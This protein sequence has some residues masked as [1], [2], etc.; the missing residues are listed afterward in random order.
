LPEGVYTFVAWTHCSDD[1]DYKSNLD[2]LIAADQPQEPEDPEESETRAPGDGFKLEQL[3]MHMQVPEN[4]DAIE[5][6]FG[7]RHYGIL[8]RAYVS[9]NSILDPL[10]ATIEVSPSIH[11]VNFTITGIGY[12]TIDDEHTLTV[13]DNNSIHNFRNQYIPGLE[14]YHHRRILEKIEAPEQPETRAVEYPILHTSMHLMQLDD[15]TKTIVQIHNAENAAQP[16]KLH[17]YDINLVEMIERA[18]TGNN[19][20]VNFDEILEFDIVID[21]TARAQIT[22]HINGWSY[23]W[24]PADLDWH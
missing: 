12:N 19:Q 23:L 17:K 18:Y 5:Q 7:H 10:P 6:N 2:E 13:I 9:N 11:K 24:V 4:G 14:P 1:G 21:L 20:P 3:L 22:F 8:Y 16:E 15:Q